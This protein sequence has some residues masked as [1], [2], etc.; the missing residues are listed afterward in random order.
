MIPLCGKSKDITYLSKY[1][2]NVVGIEFVNK[3][4]IDYFKERKLTFEESKN[5][6]R[7]KNITLINEDILKYGHK[8]DAINYIYDR[9]ALIALPH[10][11]R[12]KYID[13]IKSLTPEDSFLFLI[14]IEYDQS[15]TN[16]PPFSVPHKEILHNFSDRDITLKEERK[17]LSPSPKFIEDEI[18][19]RVYFIKN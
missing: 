6:Y 14:T 16:G 2:K 11:L 3:A 5:T 15:L 1:F 10:N 13:K 7:H 4:I 12:K 18:I 9:A 19:Q 17:I 8:T